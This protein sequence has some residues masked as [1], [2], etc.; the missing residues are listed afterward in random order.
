MPLGICAVC[1]NGLILVVNK[2]VSIYLYLILNESYKLSTEN[3][4]I[5]F[6]KLFI[7]NNEIL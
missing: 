6:F 7:K 3:N 2:H 1:L 5:V 4:Y